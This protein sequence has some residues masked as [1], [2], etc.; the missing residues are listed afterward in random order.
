M[1]ESV[2]DPVFGHLDW[3][4]HLAWWVGSVEFAPGHRIDVFVTHDLENG[5]PADE[6]AA[7]RRSLARIRR[8]EP[9]YRRWSAGRLLGARWNTD[10]PMTAEGIAGLLRVTSLEF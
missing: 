8:Q 3:E 6:I 9:E 10:E 2:D 1:P 5:R 7:A 4:G